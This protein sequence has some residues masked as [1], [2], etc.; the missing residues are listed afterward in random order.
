MI[1][2]FHPL[3]EIPFEVGNFIHNW[4]S[5]YAAFLRFVLYIIQIFLRLKSDIQHL[6]G[7]KKIG[8]DVVIL[9]LSGS[10]GY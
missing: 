8:Y 6:L 9:Y 2:A 1:D 3:V 4:E 5:I 10:N 7:Y